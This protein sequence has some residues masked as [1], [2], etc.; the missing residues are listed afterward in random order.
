MRVSFVISSLAA[1]GAQR[2]MSSMANAWVDKGWSVSLITISNSDEDFFRLS[3][4]VNRYALDQV[5]AS[6]NIIQALSGNIRRIYRL[7]KALIASRPDV[8]ISFIDMVNVLTILS[9]TGL[10][11]PVIISERVNPVQHSIGGFWEWLRKKAYSRA[12]ALVVQER[13]VRQWALNQWPELNI[14]V[15]HNPVQLKLQR[16]VKEP[17]PM[18]GRKWIAGMGR[19]EVQKG[20]DLLIDAFAM[21]VPDIPDEWGLVIIGE[22]SQRRRLECLIKENGLEDRVLLIG[23]VAMPENYLFQSDIF[24]LS[25]RYEGFPNALLEGMASGLAVISFNCPSGPA[26]IIHHDIDGI[27]VEH[28]NVKDLSVALS[29]L[30]LDDRKRSELKSAAVKNVERFAMEKILP[31]WEMLIENMVSR[32]SSERRLIK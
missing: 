19:L 11:V 8:V 23:E 26:E 13:D 6:S 30:I 20:F 28:E 9:V 18:S 25:S 1:G 16:I 22:G 10:D 7:R 14:H 29:K 4:S 21:A 3:G 12:S 2:V 32:C 27:L 24:V 15:I 31:Q 17:A 5:S